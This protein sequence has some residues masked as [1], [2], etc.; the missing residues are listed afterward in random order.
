MRAGVLASLAI[1]VAHESVKEGTYVSPLRFAI[2]HFGLGERDQG[3]EW[4][5]KALK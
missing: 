5:E 2:V 4:L 3:F 1:G